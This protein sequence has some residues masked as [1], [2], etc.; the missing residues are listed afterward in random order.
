MRRRSRHGH[1]P[2]RP[3][4]AP[5]PRVIYLDDA[6]DEELLLCPR[7]LRP[8]ASDG[9]DDC[10]APPERSSTTATARP[11]ARSESSQQQDLTA[12]L[13]GSL[14]DALGRAWERIAYLEAELERRDAVHATVVHSG[15]QAPTRR[16]PY[17]RVCADPACK[18]VLSIYNAGPCCTGHSAPVRVTSP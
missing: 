16:Y 17:G 15:I 3:L 6:P 9:H 4:P 10:E 1:T 12:E 13:V 8:G 5:E 18:V 14:T 7:C 2:S 11:P